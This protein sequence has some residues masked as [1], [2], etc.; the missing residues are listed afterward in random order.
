MEVF[1]V[2]F[3]KVQNPPPR[4]SFRAE[5]L[6]RNEKKRF[7]GSVPLLLFAPV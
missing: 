1:M 6:L 3:A 4:A 5:M 2:S 7:F